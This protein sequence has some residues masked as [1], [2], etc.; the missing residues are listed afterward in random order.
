MLIS[1]GAPSLRKSYRQYLS[2]SSEKQSSGDASD[3]CGHIVLD[4]IVPVTASDILMS[5]SQDQELRT[6]TNENASASMYAFDQSKVKLSFE[7]SRNFSG[8]LLTWV[9]NRISVNSSDLTSISGNMSGF[10]YFHIDLIVKHVVFTCAIA[11]HGYGRRSPVNVDSIVN[12]ELRLDI[13]FMATQIC[14][15]LLQV[16]VKAAGLMDADAKQRVL[17]II[18][19]N[20]LVAAVG[21][22]PASCLCGKTLVQLQKQLTW[23]DR[24]KERIAF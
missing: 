8:L 10:S 14:E 3:N 18:R 24:P 6:K 19:S 12:S 15:D 5:G 22:L 7:I 20:G 2:L 23:M 17:S 16:L 9:E 21:E 4:S 11:S 1:I 13:I